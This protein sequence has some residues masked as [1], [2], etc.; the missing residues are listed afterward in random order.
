MNAAV[1]GSSEERRLLIERIGGVGP[2]VWDNG[3]KPTVVYDSDCLTLWFHPNARVMHHKVHRA[4]REGEWRAAF[5]TGAKV[6]GQ[7]G[8]KKWLSDVRLHFILPPEDQVWMK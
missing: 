7:R 1:Q 5:L 4:V 3:I 2:T 8:G 6:L